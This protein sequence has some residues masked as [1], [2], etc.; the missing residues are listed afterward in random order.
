MIRNLPKWL[1]LGT[2]VLTFSVGI[3]NAVVLMNHHGEAASH[4]TGNLTNLAISLSDINIK[5]RELAFFILAF[6]GGACLSGAV[7]GDA[8]FKLGR[9]YGVALIIQSGII[10]A[11]YFFLNRL[12]ILGAYLLATACGLQNAMISTYSGATIRTS[13]VTGV[14]SDLGSLLGNLL[15]R[16]KIDFR[17]AL[18]LIFIFIGFFSG[19]FAGALLFDYLAWATLLISC[20][21]SFTAGLAYLVYRHWLFKSKKGILRRLEHEAH[22][23]KHA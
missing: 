8:N 5:S 2:S 15:S 4:M 18:L 19:C 3:I 21:I 7:I 10:F 1:V 16:R 23:R 13:H 20:G 14:V 12:N 11:G 9:R 17:H 22:E 6:L